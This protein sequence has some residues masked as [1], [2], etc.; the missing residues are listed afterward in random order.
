MKSFK[1]FSK[2]FDPRQYD[3][4]G[5]TFIGV[6]PVCFDLDIANTARRYRK[7][8]YMDNTS[9]TTLSANIIYEHE[10]PYH[11]ADVIQIMGNQIFQLPRIPASYINVTVRTNAEL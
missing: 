11:Q 8:I 10:E 5:F 1:F 2:P 9:N 3:I 7:M 4:E 6:S